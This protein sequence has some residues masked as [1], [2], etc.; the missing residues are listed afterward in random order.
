[1]YSAEG[2]IHG[3]TYDLKRYGSL[4]T[5]FTACMRPRHPGRG[6]FSNPLEDFEYILFLTRATSDVDP[7]IFSPND[8]FQFVLEAAV[9]S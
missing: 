6:Y 3:C 1:M 8:A 9:D 4:E 2:A 7:V 5:T